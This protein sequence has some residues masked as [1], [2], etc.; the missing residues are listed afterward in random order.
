MKVT[1]EL[2]CENGRYT[3]TFSDRD[4]ELEFDPNMWAVSDIVLLQTQAMLV[5]YPTLY[6]TV[7][8]D[9]DMIVPSVRFERALIGPIDNKEAMTEAG[10]DLDNLDRSYYWLFTDAFTGKEYVFEPIIQ[11]ND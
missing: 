1:T 7:C 4:Y 11:Y 6:V 2:R 5:G 9:M 3:F 8:R 10:V